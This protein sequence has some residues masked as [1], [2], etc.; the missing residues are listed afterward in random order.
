MP[1][2]LLEKTQTECNVAQ[3]IVRDA[4]LEGIPLVA[5]VDQMRWTNPTIVVRHYDYG[6]DL[7]LSEIRV[8]QTLVKVA[9][10]KL[11]CDLHYTLDT[12]RFSIEQREKRQTISSGRMEGYD[13]PD[14]NQVTDDLVSSWRYLK[15]QINC[16]CNALKLL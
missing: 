1:L 11:D 6:F 10:D 7:S 16:N 12:L 5:D 15:W 3:R 9:A 14:P 13:G 2:N 8:I 4:H